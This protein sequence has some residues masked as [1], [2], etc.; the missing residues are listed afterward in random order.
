MTYQQVETTSSKASLW[1][2]SQ[3]SKLYF[4]SQP[5]GKDSRFDIFEKKGRNQESENDYTTL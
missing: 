4:N 1:D 5:N 2:I 3:E